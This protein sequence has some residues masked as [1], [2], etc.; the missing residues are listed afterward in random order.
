MAP[1]KP[2][3][4]PAAK[5]PAVKPIVV[6]ARKLPAKPSTGG[7]KTSAWPDAPPVG[8]GAGLFYDPIRQS[9]APPP[10]FENVGNPLDA[11][12]GNELDRL[13]QQDVD[14]ARGE[15]GTG[16][17]RIQEDLATRLANLQRERDWSA[18]DI[19]K[20]QEEERRQQAEIQRQLPQQLE[21]VKTS[22]SARGVEFG[23]RKTFEVGETQKAA[24]E[25]IA[26]SGR[27]IEAGEEAIRRGETE[28]E[29]ATQSAQKEA[30]RA[31]QDLER[32]KA[33]FERRVRE[34]ELKGKAAAA[35]AQKSQRSEAGSWTNARYHELVASGVDP[36]AARS[37]AIADARG[38]YPKVGDTW[39][40]GALAG[41]GMEKKDKF[42]GKISVARGKT[43]TPEK[44]AAIMRTKLYKQ[45]LD[46]LPQL[47]P[48]YER[49][50]TR[51]ADVLDALFAKNRELV[52]KHPQILSLV[53]Y[54][55][56]LR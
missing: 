4:R 43:F 3:A 21:D 12:I 53:L 8:S 55:E 29:S 47:V 20:R 22:H 40:S 31:K 19:R 51:A 10:T 46:A 6:P 38:A 56:D 50:V 14:A 24:D 30:D 18:A 52:E 2:A 39:I 42:A 25:R 36:T 54:N 13:G 49:G 34:G 7:V 35:E 41:K 17:G 9:P 15:F 33:D 28:F 27:D 32:Q 37:R 5:K 1:R 16:L 11:A 44:R 23:G 26:A 48:G 45:A